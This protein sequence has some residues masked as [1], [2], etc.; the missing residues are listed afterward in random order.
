MRFPFDDPVL[1]D[2]RRTHK[3][4]CN[5]RNL[6]ELD[7]MIKVMLGVYQKGDPVYRSYKNLLTAMLY[8]KWEPEERSIFRAYYEEHKDTIEKFREC[9]KN[10]GGVDLDLPTPPLGISLGRLKCFFGYFDTGRFQQNCNFIRLVEKR[11]ETGRH[12][13]TFFSE[14]RFKLT[15]KS[16]EE[17]TGPSQ[18]SKHEDLE[19]TI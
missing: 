7:T 11:M 18:L 19:V 9:R 16:T 8:L 10:P 17:N 12:P 15:Q 13:V 6:E 5:V 14:E 2:L 4:L 1:I 3:E